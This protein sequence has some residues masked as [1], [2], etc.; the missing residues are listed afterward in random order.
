M[1]TSFAHSYSITNRAYPFTIWV[2][3]KTDIV[4]LA[5]SGLYY[6]SADGSYNN[7][8]LDYSSV[9]SSAFM[10][11]LTADLQ[12]T[13]DASGRANLTIMIHGLG[14]TYSDALAQAADVG[15][16][17]QQVGYPGLV[18]GFSW[19]SYS[20]LVAPRAD[21]YASGRPPQAN[22]GTIRDN[23]N[24]SVASFVA[25]LTQLQGIMV[26]GKPVNISVIA[27]SEGN[28]ML[29]W[30]MMKYPATVPRLNHAILLAADISAA[31]LQTGQ[32]GAGITN[33]FTDVSVYYS[34]CDADVNYSDYE[35]FAFHNQTYPTRLGL[36]G[37]FAYP[38]A[39]GMPKNVAGIDCSQVTVNLG[40]ILDVHSSYMSLP[41][42]LKDMAAVLT[43]SA[44]AGRTLFPGSSYPTNYYMNPSQALPA[45]IEAVWLGQVKMRPTLRL[46]RI[47][48]VYL[49]G[50]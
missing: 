19:P 33:Q 1:S 26:N 36:I 42:V 50:G 45:G 40:D 4:P 17:L 9:S 11:N 37:P 10:A 25:M 41:P 31:M 15:S 46:R 8:W 29:M 16:L 38:A 7:R 14:N 35:F 6:Y 30:G 32:A 34:G 5:G 3:S 23:I 22:S 48:A 27:H 20:I 18:I 49:G 12:Q 13:V 2:D 47:T 44:P 43:A 39:A 28:F 24:G 21:Y